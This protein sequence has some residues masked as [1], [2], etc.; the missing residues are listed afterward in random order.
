MEAGMNLFK[1]PRSKLN[2]KDTLQMDGAYSATHIN[3]GQSPLFNTVRG[4]N[5]AQNSRKNSLS[6][7]HKIENVLGCIESFNGTERNLKKED[8][9]VL[10]KYYW[11]EY[12]HVF[13]EL[14][15]ILPHSVVTAYIGRHAIEIG[16]KYL[17]IK[18]H[19][20]ADMTHDLGILSNSLF[21]E[22]DIEKRIDTDYKY[23]K[24]INDYCETYFN[25][26]EGGNPEYFRYPEYKAK[27]YFAGNRTDIRWLS[28]NFAL[29]L[30]KL[31]HFDHFDAKT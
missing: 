17:L 26:I 6:L 31:L 19:G 1:S 8:Q 22:Y 29:I 25:F 4:L 16:L 3:Y 5:L 21:R 28:Y 14:R 18:K 23:M 2:Y 24:Y 11:L 12:I 20:K 7:F 9:V 15:D 27:A 10:W 13:N 30:L